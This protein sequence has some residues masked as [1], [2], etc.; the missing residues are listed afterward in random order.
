MEHEQLAGRTQDCRRGFGHAVRHDQVLNQ[1]VHVGVA[2][3][4]EVGA[5]VRDREQQA[6]RSAPKSPSGTPQL[7]AA[8]P[9]AVAQRARR[10]ISPPSKWAVSHVADVIE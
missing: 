1:V 10:E 8:F 4:E 5:F 2:A 3:D 6:L 9:G 7:A